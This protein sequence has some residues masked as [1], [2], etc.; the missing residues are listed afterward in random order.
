MML[1]IEQRLLSFVHLPFS[2]SGQTT[3][4]NLPPQIPMFTF[5]YSFFFVS[6]THSK[7]F[8]CIGASLQKSLTP[9]LTPTPTPSKNPAINIKVA[10]S[11]N[12]LKSSI[13]ISILNLFRIFKTIIS[14]FK[15]RSDA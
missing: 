8:S 1:Y 15:R 7:V 12:G 2:K 6:K 13:K 4:F 14:D 11:I 3:Y 10:L 9:M 5:R